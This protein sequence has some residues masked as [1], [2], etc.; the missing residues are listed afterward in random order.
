M[1]RSFIHQVR[2]RMQRG[3]VPLRCTLRRRGNRA[4]LRHED[5]FLCDAGTGYVHTITPITANVH[6][7]TQTHALVCEDN[8]IVHGVSGY[9]VWKSARK[10][11]NFRPLRRGLSHCKK[12]AE[13]HDERIQK[14]ESG[15]VEFMPVGNM[16]LMVR[17][18]SAFPYAN[19]SK[20]L[21]R[22]LQT[23]YT[24]PCRVSV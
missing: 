16:S 23:C 4:V 7:I 12:L 18:L 22:R 17:V 5:P 21:A 3:R 6:D 1:Q 15:T 8:H 20:T 2:P 13:P 14:N 9:P 19:L 11:E 10:S 24:V